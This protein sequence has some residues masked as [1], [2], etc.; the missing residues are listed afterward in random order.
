MSN[1]EPIMVLIVDNH[2]EMANGI[3]L[4]LGKDPD[5]IVSDKLNRPPDP[6][7]PGLRF[8]ICVLDLIGVATAQEITDFV[9]KRA[10]LIYTVEDRWQQRFAA[11]VCGARSVVGKNVNG[12]TLVEAVRDALDRPHFLSPHLAAALAQAIREYQLPLPE[13]IGPLLEEFAGWQPPREALI[14]YGVSEEQWKADLARLRQHCRKVGLGRL[15]VSGPGDRCSADTASNGAVRLPQVNDLTPTEQDVLACR[16]VGMS[17]EDIAAELGIPTQD[18]V[19]THLKNAMKKFGFS[20][21]GAEAGL[22]FAMYVMGQ[23]R[24]PDR[25]LCRLLKERGTP[26]PPPQGRPYL[27]L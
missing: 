3:E 22:L 9:S 11:W 13:H 27:D 19:R 7:N 18:T 26:P 8:D 23:H 10:S 1:R 6:D 16:A 14:S 17:L 12:R 5:L 4:T 2:R 24:Q 20:T 15:E 21:C 25:L